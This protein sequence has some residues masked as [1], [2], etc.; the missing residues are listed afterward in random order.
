MESITRKTLMNR[1]VLIY[2]SITF[3]HTSAIGIYSV[4]IIS[5][6]QINKQT[7]G[8]EI[9]TIYGENM[10]NKDVPTSSKEY[11]GS[12]QYKSSGKSE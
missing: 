11:A 8:V 7:C 9:T 3:F 1:K 5:D 12:F 2:S 10:D 4:S 6:K